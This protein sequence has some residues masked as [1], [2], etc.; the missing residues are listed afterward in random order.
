M[1]ILSERQERAFPSPP[2]WSLITRFHFRNGRWWEIPENNDEGVSDWSKLHKAYQL[3]LARLEDPN[4]DGAG[5]IEQEEGG[6]LVPGLGKAGFDLSQKS[7]EWRRGY[8]DILMG[9]ARAAEHL[10]GW[11]WDKT[12]KDKKKAAWPPEMIIGP[13]NPNPHP[14]PPGAPPPPLEENCVKVSDPPETYYLKILTSKGFITHQKITAA[15]G[16]ADW[17]SFKGL[18]ESAEGMYKWGLDI[19]CSGLADPSTTIDPTT[20]VISASAPSVTP[21]VVL[22]ATT[23]AVHHA[24]TGNVSSALPIFLSV[25]RARRTA[26]LAPPASRTPQEQS[27]LLSMV[28]DLIQTPPYPPPPPTGDEPLLRSPSDICEEAVLMNYIGEIL[29]ASSTSASQ[30]ATGL[31]W[32][33]EA[34][35]V[36]VEGEKNESFSKDVKKKCLECEEVGLENWAKMVKRLV[37]EAE[38]RKMVDSGWKGWIGL[39]PKEEETKN[40]E[41]EER[42]VTSRLEKL[43]DSILRERFEEA[44]RLAGRVFVV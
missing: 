31:S 20:G 18:K 7:E 22:A 5:L 42:D 29:F 33:R 39:G 38:E 30:R 40:L 28:V 43:R 3:A 10:D 1:A 24:V 37:K 23:L 34:V 25:L 12:S 41:E 2:E 27:T 44:D 11:V 15:L 16:Y 8:Y 17:L 13:S 36:A 4:K 32:T 6:I 21:N 26:P 19:A 9:M 14:P 35:Q